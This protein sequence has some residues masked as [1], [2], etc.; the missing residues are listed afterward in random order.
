M[1]FQVGDKVI[2]LSH[3]LG[4]IVNIEPRTIGDNLMDCYV[5][6]TPQLTIWTPVDE[7]RNHNLRMPTSPDEFE[8]LF[9]ILGGPG[10][11]LEQDRIL[12]KDH[13]L[14]QLRDGQLTSIC[15]VVRDLCHYKRAAKLNDQEKSILERATNSLLAEWVYSLG[16][17]SSQAEQEMGILLGEP[18]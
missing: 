9:A 4:E 13:L 17:S 6:R 7:E 14:S 11:V 15:K 1:G 3:G 12:R 10:E 18:A 5:V 2:H 16:V 8:D